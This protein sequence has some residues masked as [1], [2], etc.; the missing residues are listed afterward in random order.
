M[1][2]SL[3]WLLTGVMAITFGALLYFQIMYLENMVKMREAQFSE[4][5]L[6]CLSSTG[7]YLEK[8]ETMHFLQ[9]DI[10]VMESSIMDYN[11]QASSIWG[12]SK[13]PLS[14]EIIDSISGLISEQS[15]A[16]GL[17]GGL[18]QQIGRPGSIDNIQN[19]YRNM[20]QT[21]RGQ[22]LYQRGLLNEVILSILRDAGNRPPKERADSTIIRDYLNNELQESGLNMPFNFSVTNARGQLIYTTNKFEKE[23]PKN[24][25][26][27]TLFPNTG[28][29]LKLNVE[30]PQRNRYIFSSV[31][32]I[33]PTLIFT[34]ILLIVFLITI[35][36][37]FRQKKLSEIKTD[38]IHNMTHELKTP[39]STISLASQML[40]DSSVRKSEASLNRLAGVISDETKRLQ[41]QVEKVLQMSVFDNSD[42]SVKLSV[43]DANEVIQNV[44]D[45]FKIKVEKF[46]G[47]ISSNLRARDSFVEVD[48]MHFT[49]II[50]N[51]LD[52]AIKYRDEDRA[53]NLGVE[54]LNPN[55]KTL[56]IRVKDNG[57]GIKKEDLRRIFDKFYRVPTGNRHDVKGFGLGLA[58]VKKMV[59]IFKGSI[60]AESEFGKGSV[61]IINL[62]LA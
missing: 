37:A 46:G 26:T 29:P 13:G 4:I 15:Q 53:P 44:V 35:I 1:K 11:N 21:L 33:I 49:N 23:S 30:F 43:T 50:H 3:I 17:T 48:Q 22:Y 12:L 9:E 39:I 7:A 2:K 32:F 8:R 61:F 54:T 31:R 60:S 34:V 56:Q 55:E 57:I 5:V 27:Q 47:S 58:Y 16:L 6:R 20:Q 52:N 51:L 28:T 10:A 40:N 38:F 19:R 14:N 36:M 42:A 45:T 59:E 25:Y 62:P 24:L 18:E 41:F